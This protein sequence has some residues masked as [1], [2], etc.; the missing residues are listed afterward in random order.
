MKSLT[1]IFNELSVIGAEMEEEDKVLH[2]LTSLP[3]TNDTLVTVLEANAT[4]PSMEVVTERL[5]KE[6]CKLKEHDHTTTT[7]DDGGMVVMYA[8]RQNKGPKCY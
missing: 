2:L 4:V 7:I 1:E 8:H 5:F 6:E 3:S